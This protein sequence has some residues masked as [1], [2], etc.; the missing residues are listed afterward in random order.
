MYHTICEG[1]EFDAAGDQ[2]WE[3]S[4]KCVD[5]GNVPEPDEEL[6]VSV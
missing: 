6:L 2:E 5:P 1:T 4:L 3:P